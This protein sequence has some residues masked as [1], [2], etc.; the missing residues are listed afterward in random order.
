MKK[1][2][3]I[4]YISIGSIFTLILTF[5]IF[6]FAAPSSNPTPSSNQTITTN[7]FVG[8][9]TLI[10]KDN[11]KITL[12]NGSK[13]ADFTLN[14]DTIIYRNGQKTTLDQLQYNDDVK[15]ILNS[16][17]VVRYV[18]ATSNKQQE[19]SSSIGSE[20]QNNAQSQSIDSDSNPSSN[21]NNAISQNK[22]Q[23]PSLNV[24]ELQ[25]HIDY[26]HGINYEMHYHKN[27]QGKVDSHI[28][29]K[30][31][32]QNI[33]AKDEQATPFIESFIKQLALTPYSNENEILSK[34]QSTLGVKEN[35]FKNLEF[36]VKFSNGNEVHI[37]LDAKKKRK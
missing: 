20:M 18:V 19:N 5:T 37:H 15:I 16:E 12:F 25:L 9:P 3:K 21:V 7:E 31:E 22:E 34:V 17:Q 32:N 4:G 27:D 14:S 28:H 6:T 33:E 35:T 8:N 13:K 24:S 26:G 1:I 36:K 2:G 29:K 30:T 10:D 23:S 11:N